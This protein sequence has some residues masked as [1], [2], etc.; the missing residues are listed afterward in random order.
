MNNILNPAQLN[1]Y[2]SFE[3]LFFVAF[4][5]IM[6]REIYRKDVR[7]VLEI[8]S[9]AVFGVILELGDTYLAHTYSYSQNFLAQI[10]HIPLAIGFGWAVI[11]YC[12][13]LLSDQYNTPWFLRPFM[14]ALTA[15]LL[16]IA[17][18]A[19]AI[20]LGFW[21]WAISLNQ[22]W[23]GVP[24]ENFA[25]WIFVVLSFSFLIRFLR[26]LN[27]KRLV[28]RLLFSISPLLA[29][30]G[31]AGALLIYSAVA[32]LPYAV[33]NW[34]I[35]LSFN[36]RPD[37]GILYNPQV[38]FWKIIL[39]SVIIVELANIVVWSIVRYR[40]NYIKRLDLL[41]F[42]ILAGIY[43]FFLGA[44]FATGI[45]AEMPM[46]VLIGVA[47]F[48]VY[49]AAHF[50]PYILMRPKLVYFFRGA[51][52]RALRKELEIENVLKKSLE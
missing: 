7:R 17:V 38:Q 5:A 15:V 23:Y 18:D 41:S 24:F 43:L 47:A 6:A 40:K 52:E 27:M 37:F 1:W 19:V 8:L 30:G 2:A 29:Y 9:A 25:G 16:D 36:Y 13:M 12:A 46:L 4:A 31:L 51:K 26:T 44:L 42:S 22:E 35:F 39:F 20:R 33:N 21:Q 50:L 48:L 49:C 14:D 11:I 45:Y 28:P 3:I 32:I 10:F 34:A